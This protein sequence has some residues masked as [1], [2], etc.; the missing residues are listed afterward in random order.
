[1]EGHKNILVYSTSKMHVIMV[2]PRK[3]EK[4]DT[5][6]RGGGTKMFYVFDGNRENVSLPW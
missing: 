2:W 6:S 4:F 3:G 5:N 1:M